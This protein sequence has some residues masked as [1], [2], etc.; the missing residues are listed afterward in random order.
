MQHFRKQCTNGTYNPNFGLKIGVN[1][2]WQVYFAEIEKKIKKVAAGGCWLSRQQLATFNSKI[3]FLKIR[4]LSI[5]YLGFYP[6]NSP[7]NG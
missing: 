6:K 5:M 2:P 7:K 1:T 3:F 4:S